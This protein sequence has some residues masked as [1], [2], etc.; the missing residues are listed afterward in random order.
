MGSKLRPIHL[1]FVGVT[2]PPRSLSNFDVEPS[3]RIITADITA[4]RERF[5]AAGWV[6]RKRTTCTLLSR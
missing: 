3:F 6:L 4:I 5:C 1:R 2:E